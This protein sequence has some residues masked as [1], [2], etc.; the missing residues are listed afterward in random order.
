VGRRRTRADGRSEGSLS[1]HFVFKQLRTAARAQSRINLCNFGFADCR[2]AGPGV[3][4]SKHP[5]P[6]QAF[7]AMRLSRRSTADR[8]PPICGAR[9]PPSCKSLARDTPWQSPPRCTRLSSVSWSTNCDCV[10]LA[11]HDTLMVQ[12]TVSLN[13]GLSQLG[14]SDSAVSRSYCFDFLAG[15]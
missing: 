5:C 1:K 12:L 7:S 2:I 11:V 4:T 13:P 10:L 6:R 8:V 14:T 9:Q 3:S 15:K